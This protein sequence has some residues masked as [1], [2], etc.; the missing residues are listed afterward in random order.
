MEKLK[1]LIETAYADRQNLS[2]ERVSP[3]IRDAIHEVIR[4]LDAGQLRVAEKQN[5]QWITHQWIKMAVFLYFKTE[6]CKAFE[7]GYL[8][9]NTK[10]ML[11]LPW[12]TM[13]DWD[14][15]ESDEE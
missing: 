5:G 8:N 10:S 1:T 9:D 14:T 3:S 7:A 2:P 13:C 15:D 12:E 11:E 6:P 4:Q